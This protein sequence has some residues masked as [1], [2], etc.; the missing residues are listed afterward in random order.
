ML[1]RFSEA[2]LRT[3]TLVRYSP[4]GYCRHRTGTR[5]RYSPMLGR[6]LALVR[7]S[8]FV[9]CSATYWYVR[10]MLTDAWSSTG[11]VLVRWYETQLHATYWY[12]R[13]ILTD[14]RLRT[15]ALVRYSPMLG[16]LL[17]RS[18]DTQLTSKP[19]GHSGSRICRPGG[20]CGPCRSGVSY[21][22]LSF[23]RHD[24]PVDLPMLGYV[25][26]VLTEALPRTGT[27][28]RYSATYWYAR[29][30]LTD[31]WL[32]PSTPTFLPPR[33]ST[34]LHIPYGTFVVLAI[35]FPARTNGQK[36]IRSYTSRHPKIVCDL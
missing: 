22:S 35:L 1:V 2:L 4:I 21:R 36:L 10:T 27:L 32:Q 31:A 12:A 30:I 20:P 23:S 34:Y 7:T 17:V 13:T 29:T 5:V 9:R 6:V 18:Y 16:Y 11:T 15:S 28:I 19:F 8:T 33:W 24:L 14:A 3:R 25:C 26:T